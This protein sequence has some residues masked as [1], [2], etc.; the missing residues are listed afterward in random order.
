MRYFSLTYKTELINEKGKE[1]FCVF[2]VKRYR[3]LEKKKLET[4]EHL[5]RKADLKIKKF[6]LKEISFSEYKTLYTMT[7]LPQKLMNELLTT[8]KI[9]EEKYP[10]VF[11]NP[12]F[13]LNQMN[14]SIKE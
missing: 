5:E 14:L 4:I 6:T 8:G 12:N 10:E 1:G 3:Y 9:T 7:Y 13:L 2:E 11:K